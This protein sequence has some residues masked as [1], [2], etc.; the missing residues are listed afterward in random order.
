MRLFDHTNSISNR[1]Y[2]IIH[3]LGAAC[4]AKGLVLYKEALGLPTALARRFLGSTDTVHS[5]FLLASSLCHPLGTAIDMMMEDRSSNATPKALGTVFAQF[6][7]NGDGF[8]DLPEFKRALRAIGLPRRQGDKANLDEATF[9]SMD[10]SGEGRLTPA[11]IEAR[12]PPALRAKIEQRLEAGWVFDQKRWAESVMRHSQQQRVRGPLHTTIDGVD[13]ELGY[14][15]YCFGGLK[16][17]NVTF[18]LTGCLG[19]ICCRYILRTKYGDITCVTRR[20]F[21]EF[22]AL[23]ASLSR[24]P[25]GL[26]QR[27]INFTAQLGSPLLGPTLQPKN[28]TG[29]RP[30]V[31]WLPETFPVRSKVE[32][33]AFHA[34][35]VS[36]LLHSIRLAMR[37]LEI[38]RCPSCC[39]T[40][41]IASRSA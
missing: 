30:G 35:R 19:R 12:V 4:C 23:H 37:P 11:D 2:R 26:L 32:S 25:P 41:S 6:D 5:E 13:S 16:L 8:I 14:R 39:G 10:V 3:Q 38:G 22:A 29:Q 28:E 1:K 34:A 27:V 20:R 21:A 24:T 18:M 15:R 7:A 40:T 36:Y 9:R 33:Q 31:G 17:R